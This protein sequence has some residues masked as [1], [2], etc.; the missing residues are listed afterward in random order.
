M[1][2]TLPKLGRQPLARPVRVFEA[3]PDLLDE[4]APAHARAAWHLGVAESE[5]LPEGPWLPPGREQLGSGALG[6]LVLEG[7]LMRTV[8]L[9]GR[10]APELVGAGDLLR[11][12]EADAVSGFVELDVS[13]SVIDRATVALLDERF[14]DRVCRVPGLCGALLAR[15]V[16][17]SRWMAFQAALSQIRRAEPRVL[18]LLWHLADR[19]GRVTPNGVHIPLRLTHAMLARLVSMRRPT[20]SS[21]LAALCRSQELVRADD[22]SWLLT[23][24]PPDLERVHVQRT[25]DR[26]SRSRAPRYA[27]ASP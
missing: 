9:D 24:A 1:A 22:H 14:A 18:L 7:V 21:A 11:P 8:G 16:Q 5:V 20:V 26:T 10:Q 3:D 17:R 15:S 27:Q 23:G 4:L 6:L 12:W 2:A 19:W 13:W 25:R